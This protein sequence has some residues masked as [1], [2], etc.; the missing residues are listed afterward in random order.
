M[1]RSA[2]C[3]PRMLVHE[4]GFVNHPKDPGGA[5]NRGVTLATLKRLGIDV[6]GDGD[7]DIVDL[8][9]LRETDA[10]RVY[11]LFYWDKVSADDL[12]P[13]VDFAVADFAV[14]SGP[15]RAAQ[16]L[17]R[18][19]GVEADGHVGPK[20]LAAAWKADR[21]ILINKICDSRL[22]FMRDAKNRKTGEKL[23]PTFGKGWAARVAQVRADSLADTLAAKIAPP[24][25]NSAPDG[26]TPPGI[27]DKPMW[28]RFFMAL[29]GILKGK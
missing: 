13:G 6:D 19:L 21:A 4:G 1:N 14:N 2:I 20:T 25:H 28:A 22:A 12:P 18:A 7:S 8:R 11:K 16:H 26:S 24:A 10:V 5:T 9:N 29:W 27:N 3:I 23:W 17:Q 15:V